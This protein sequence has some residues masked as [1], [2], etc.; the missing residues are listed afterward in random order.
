VSTW[1]TFFSFN[2]THFSYIDFDK[3]FQNQ[4]K[5]VSVNTTK[6]R[7]VNT[8]KD[9]VKNKPR[10]KSVIVLSESKQRQ[11][12]SRT[13]AKEAKLS[14]Q[15]QPQSHTSAKTGRA[16]ES[17]QEGQIEQVKTDNGESHLENNDQGSFYHPKSQNNKAPRLPETH[18]VDAKNSVLNAV[19]PP[20]Y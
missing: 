10:K 2:Y 8:A 12:R 14:Q 9:K 4:S 1:R 20:F 7:K 16:D 5:M 17:D 6:K 13:A 11:T 18:N 15:A 19:K 3:S